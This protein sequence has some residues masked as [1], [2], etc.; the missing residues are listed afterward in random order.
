MMVEKSETY[1]RSGWGVDPGLLDLVAHGEQHIAL[2]VI[3]KPGKEA[4]LFLLEVRLGI[5]GQEHTK[6]MLAILLGS[7][8][9]APGRGHTSMMKRI[10]SSK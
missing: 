1:M 5:L 8:T 6:V 7:H 4:L 3:V 10:L 9:Q 2:D